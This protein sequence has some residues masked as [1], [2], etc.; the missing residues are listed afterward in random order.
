MTCIL[1]ETYKLKQ[2]NSTLQTQTY[3]LYINFIHLI[4]IFKNGYIIEIV[5]I[6]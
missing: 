5:L 1:L 2:N 6:D 4:V 3:K